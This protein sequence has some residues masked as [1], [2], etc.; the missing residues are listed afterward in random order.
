LRSKSRELVIPV[1]FEANYFSLLP[2]E[3]MK[4]KVQVNPADLGGE[5][6]VFVLDGWNSISLEKL[7][8]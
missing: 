4:I 7:L 2:K 3:K 8:E 5:K 6:P 1:V